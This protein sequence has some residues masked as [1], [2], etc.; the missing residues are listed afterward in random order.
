MK[1]EYTTQSLSRTCLYGVCSFYPHPTTHWSIYRCPTKK[2]NR[3]HFHLHK[4]SPFVISLPSL[5]SWSLKEWMFSIQKFPPCYHITLSYIMGFDVKIIHQ[6]IQTL[7]LHASHC[8]RCQYGHYCNVDYVSCHNITCYTNS[9]LAHLHVHTTNLLNIT[10]ALVR[11]SP[12]LQLG[13]STNKKDQCRVN[14]TLKVATWRG[15]IGGLGCS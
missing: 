15:L 10:C 13:W 6:R 9:A 2:F 8:H 11:D 5:I 1:F 14:G 12:S 4:V 7:R 3:I